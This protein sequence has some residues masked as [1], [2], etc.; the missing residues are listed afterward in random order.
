MRITICD[1]DEYNLEVLKL[2]LELEGY[3]VSAINGSIRLIERIKEYCPDILLVDLWMPVISG[4]E[5]IKI[6]R[7]DSQ[8]KKLIVIAFSASFNGKK[9]ALDAGANYYITKPFDIDEVTKSIRELAIK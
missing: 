5:I 1:D 3:E 8:L 6:I 2:L 4:D 9:I 7:S